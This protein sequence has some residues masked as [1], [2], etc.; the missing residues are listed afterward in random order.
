[1][2]RTGEGA[3]IFFLFAGFWWSLIL[4]AKNDYACWIGLHCQHKVLRGSELGKGDENFI[5]GG[6]RFD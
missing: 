4:R 6:N 1:M 5:F 3:A 2:M